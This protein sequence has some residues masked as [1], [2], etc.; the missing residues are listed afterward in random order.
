MKKR[1]IIPIFVPHRG[2]P[3]ACVFC[4]QASITGQTAAVDGKTV[5]EAIA[6]YRQTIPA[7]TDKTVE[8]AFYG[9]SFTGIP[10]AEQSELL[11]PAAQALAAGQID[12]IRLSTRPDY[13][14]RTILANL[15]HYRVRTIELGVQ[16]LDAAVLAAAKRGHTADAVAAAVDLIREFGFDLGLQLMLGLPDDNPVKFRE[17]VRQTIALRPDFVRIYP[18]LI[19]KGTELAEL[20]REGRYRPLSLPE[21]VDLAKTALAA[22]SRSGIPVIRVGLQPTEDIAAGSEVVAGPFHP[23]F[24]QLVESAMFRDALAAVARKYPRTAA[25]DLRVNPREE[26]AARGK[27]NGNL[28]W[29]REIGGPER[30]SLRTDAAVPAGEICLSAVDGETLDRCFRVV[31]YC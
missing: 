16:S 21:A 26:T 7:G 12:G 20:Y 8:V 23:A 28:A 31:D 11:V 10:L 17:T 4:N 22:F 5:E 19:L 3:H 30:V 27:R 13:I 2:C 1:Y 25:L 14:D 18:T 15:R 6:A 24:R 9:G 29:L